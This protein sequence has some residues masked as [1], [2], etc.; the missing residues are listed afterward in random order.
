M[1]FRKG[2]YKLCQTFSGVCRARVQPRVAMSPDYEALKF[3]LSLLNVLGVL[4]VGI[5]T[6][7][8][9]RDR[10]TQAAIAAVREELTKRLDVVVDQ[11][12]TAVARVAEVEHDVSERL[13]LSDLADLYQGLNNLGREMGA[14]T[15]E[16][17]S[18]T[19]QMTIHSEFLLRNGGVIGL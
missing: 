2:A 3:Y 10:A 12:H 19:R 8:T 1:K 11:V 16:L 9:N 14:M 15:A 4:V 6:W 18:V 17:K 7:W 13:K 5:Y